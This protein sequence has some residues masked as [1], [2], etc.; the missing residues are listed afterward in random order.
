MFDWDKGNRAKCQKHGVSPEEIEFVLSH[1]V[2]IRPAKTVYVQEQRSYAMGRNAEGRY[3]FIVFTIRQIE[4][5]DRL[6]PI[7]ARYMHRKE[8]ERY[9]KAKETSGSQER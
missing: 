6:R 2:A 7:S 4:G 5:E 3:I 8:I 9:E 1:P